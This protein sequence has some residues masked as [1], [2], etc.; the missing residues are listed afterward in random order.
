MS[1]IIEVH[2]DYSFIDSGLSK[3]V[4]KAYSKNKNRKEG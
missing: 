4:R 1:K 2:E 3:E